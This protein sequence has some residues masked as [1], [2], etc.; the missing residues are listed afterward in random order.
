MSEQ[1]DD[2]RLSDSPRPVKRRRLG[3]GS[4]FSSP[5]PDDVN[6][7][8]DSRIRVTRSGQDDKEIRERKI[9]GEVPDSPVGRQKDKA[10]NSSEIDHASNVDLNGGGEDD[11]MAD[12][13]ARQI[14]NPKRKRGRPPKSTKVSNL[15]LSDA[16]TLQRQGGPKD[17]EHRTSS[18][19]ALRKSG[20][21]RRRPTLLQDEL[22]VASGSASAKDGDARMSPSR[23]VSPGDVVDPGDDLGFK[24]IPQVAK[25]SSLRGAPRNPPTAHLTAGRLE[26]GSQP[27][28]LKRK[29]GRPRKSEPSIGEVRIV[30]RVPSQAVTVTARPSGR[31]ETSGLPDFNSSPSTPVK[32]RGRPPKRKAIPEAT[33]E[34]RWIE[35]DQNHGNGRQE[36]TADIWGAVVSPP[37]PKR[38]RGRPPRSKSVD[39]ESRPH[40]EETREESDV[41]IDC[42][43]SD[44]SGLFTK[45]MQEV[46]SEAVAGM[47]R[48]TLLQKLTGRRRLPLTGLDEEYRKV[49]QVVKQTIVAGEGN[50]LLVIGGRGTGK[51]TVCFFLVLAYDVDVVG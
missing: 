40:D 24:D 44:L 26:A 30:E 9:Y 49:H 11:E 6:A 41:K 43:P 36:A 51:T 32:K 33:E 19:P 21:V 2:A 13:T 14:Q 1:A 48:D 16:I 38:K 7:A 29:R 25:P 31:A 39:K 15:P 4:A 47:L 34:Q 8:V 45:L 10:H 20:R 35:I 42:R 37:P 17:E 22:D 12:Q 18:N 5:T 3:K 46:R 27:E 50:S 23:D 28:P